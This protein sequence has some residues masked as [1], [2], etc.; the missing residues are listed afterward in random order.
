MLTSAKLAHSHLPCTRSQLLL[1]FWQPAGGGQRSYF[2]YI[3]F[4]FFF[5]NDKSGR[6]MAASF[7]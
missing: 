3:T 4:L 1:G 5:V 2:N 7:K 6:S